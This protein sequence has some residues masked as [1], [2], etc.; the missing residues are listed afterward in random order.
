MNSYQ[1]ELH[2]SPEEPNVVRILY[3]DD[4]PPADVDKAAGQVQQQYPGLRVVKLPQPAD[5]STFSY[6]SEY[7]AFSYDL[8]LKRPVVTVLPP[9]LDMESDRNLSA[10]STQRYVLLKDKAAAKEL[11]EDPGSH[12]RVAA[13]IRPVAGANVETRSRNP[14]HRIQPGHTPHRA[15][16]HSAGVHHHLLPQAP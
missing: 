7:S 16:G 15:G 13:G 10:W 1:R 9:G 4:A 3:P 12:R 14:S 8:M 2:L 5:F 11:S 6:Q